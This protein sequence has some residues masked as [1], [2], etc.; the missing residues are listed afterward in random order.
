MCIYVIMNVGV[1]IL[2]IV[3]ELQFVVLC[4]RVFMCVRN[5][6]CEGSILVIVCVRKFVFL[7]ISV[8]VCVRN[9]E[10]GC[11]NIGDSM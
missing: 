8:C 6:E 5:H 3:C 7:C 1:R 2:V 9:H 4:I 11:S 10:C